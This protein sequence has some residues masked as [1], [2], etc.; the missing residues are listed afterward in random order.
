[1]F[2][3]EILIGFVGDLFFSFVQ[4]LKILPENLSL[5][6]IYHLLN[7]ECVNFIL[8]FKRTPASFLS[9]WSVL[10]FD[11]HLQKHM[12]AF[13]A[14]MSLGTDW[15]LCQGEPPTVTAVGTTLSDTPQCPHKLVMRG[16]GK[17][18]AKIRVETS[19]RKPHFIPIETS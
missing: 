7:L 17:L 2:S 1:M 16:K 3:K 11:G 19:L 18:S 9:C 6:Y 13:L 8:R 14:E 15:L 12:R 4:C 5:Q 10:V